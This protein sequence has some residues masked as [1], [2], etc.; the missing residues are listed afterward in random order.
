MFDTSPESSGP[1]RHPPPPL[2]VGRQ[3]LPAGRIPVTC[4]FG[5]SG[6]EKSGLHQRIHATVLAEAE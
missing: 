3:P 6:L 2:F 5:G 4:S 1:N